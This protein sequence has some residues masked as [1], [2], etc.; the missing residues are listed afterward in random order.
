MTDHPVSYLSP[1][2][3]ARS[4]QNGQKG[5]FAGAAISKGEVLA[6]WGGE[7]MTQEQNS[8]LPDAVARLAI[9]VEEDLYLSGPAEDSGDFVNHSC[10]PNAG[11]SGQIVMVAMRDIAPGE[12]VCLD[13]AMCDGSEYDEF[14]CVC[15]AADC[16]GVVRGSDWRNPDLWTRYRGYFSPYLQRRIDRLQLTQA[17]STSQTDTD[18]AG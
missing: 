4:V 8:L 5:V 17:T 13:Y 16:R 3:E 9:Q 1:K 7:I 12:E 14:P 15:G 10:N 18:P 2:C 6:V 11:L